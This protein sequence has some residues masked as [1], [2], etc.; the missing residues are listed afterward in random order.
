MGAHGQ[1][2]TMRLSAEWTD[3]A[4]LLL[5]LHNQ[6]LRGV[7]VT[8]LRDFMYPL[9]LNAPRVPAVVLL[10]RGFS[11]CCKLPAHAHAPVVGLLVFS[12]AHGY[13]P[14]EGL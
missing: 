12:I 9:L 14:A 3:I 5:L 8:M 10:P 13:T 2:S 4:P 11:C 6:P 7:R 1:A